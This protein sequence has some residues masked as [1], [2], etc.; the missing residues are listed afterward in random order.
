MFTVNIQKVSLLT[1]L[2]QS[3]QK[4]SKF[5]VTHQEESMVGHVSVK[6]VY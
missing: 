3:D 6:G 5:F 2:V 1:V 4:T